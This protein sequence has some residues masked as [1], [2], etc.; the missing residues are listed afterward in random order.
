MFR[1]E[2]LAAWLIVAGRRGLFGSEK[3]P[4]REL[5]REVYKSHAARNELDSNVMTEMMKIVEDF[6]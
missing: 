1:A 4:C 2:A 5:A 3:S 6:L